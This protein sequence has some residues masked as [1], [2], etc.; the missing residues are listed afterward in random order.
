MRMW[1]CM[2]SPM[3]S[4]ARLQMVT[5]GR[6]SRPLIRNGKVRLLTFSSRTPCD[7]LRALGGKI[8]NIDLTVICEAPKIGPHRPAMREAIANICEIAIERVSVK[9]TTSERLGFTGRKEGIA[10]LASACIHLPDPDL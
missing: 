5:S 4:L 8:G 9:A 6:I 1:G 10:A 2:P 7:A 3:R